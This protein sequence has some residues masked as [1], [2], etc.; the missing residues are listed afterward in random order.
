MNKKAH[1]FA[2]GVAAA[3][4]LGTANAQFGMPAT[5]HGVPADD[6]HIHRSHQGPRVAGSRVAGRGLLGHGLPFRASIGTEIEVRFYAEVPAEAVEPFTTLA[7][8]VGEDSEAAFLEDFA[9][10]R[11]DASYLVVEIGAQTRSIELS[12]VRGEDAVSPIRLNAAHAVGL[13]HHLDL[14]DGDTVT[15]VLY[16]GDPEAGGTELQTFTFTYGEDSAIGFRHDLAAAAETADW[17][18]VTLPPQTYTFDLTNVNR[19]DRAGMRAFGTGSGG[20][21]PGSGTR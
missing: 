21:V 4:L 1:I 8:T 7:L 11:R 14:A 18:A 2:A 6:P 16:A 10:A 3:L 19:R 12:D 9:E 15:A 17:V 5:H 13:L 20:V